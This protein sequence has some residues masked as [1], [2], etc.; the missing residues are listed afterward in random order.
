MEWI[1]VPN[2]I[3][4]KVRKRMAS[5]QRKISSSTDTP[6]EKALHSSDSGRGRKLIFKFARNN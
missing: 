6:G 2:I 3:A 5:R 4:V 1:C